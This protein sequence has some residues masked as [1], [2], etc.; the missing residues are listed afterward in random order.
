[1][2]KYMSASDFAF[3]IILTTLEGTATVT[4]PKEITKQVT[5]F[6]FKVF[7][8]NSYERFFL[9][10]SLSPLSPLSLAIQG[11]FLSFGRNVEKSEIYEL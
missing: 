6:L 2:Y 3:I 4:F 1:M 5:I 8:N 10:L 11:L 7:N 9:S